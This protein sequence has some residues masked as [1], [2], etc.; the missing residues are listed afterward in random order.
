MHYMHRCPECRSVDSFQVAIV[1]LSGDHRMFAVER[2]SKIRAL[3]FNLSLIAKKTNDWHLAYHLNTDGG[4]CFRMTCFDHNL[5][6]FK[7]SKYL[8]TSGQFVIA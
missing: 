1:L 8:P 3:N 7:F 2:V 4:L 6:N 5:L